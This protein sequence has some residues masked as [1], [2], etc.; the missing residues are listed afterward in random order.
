[1]GQP[2]I[3]SVRDCIGAI[4]RAPVPTVAM[5]NGYCLGA[6]SELALACDLRV[7]H[8]DVFVGLPEVKLGIP[9]VADAALLHHYVGLSRAKE[10]I[11]TGANSAR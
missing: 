4:R 3:S 5:I 6:A 9:S 10:I 8:L 2:L 11:L 1:V 7:A